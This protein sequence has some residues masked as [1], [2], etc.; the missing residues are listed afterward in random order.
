MPKAIEWTD[1]QDSTIRTMRAERA[2]W[3]AIAAA[4]RLSRYT[5]IERGRDIG[6][7]MAEREAQPVT[8]DSRIPLPAGHSVSWGAIN[9]ATCLA[10]MAYPLPVFV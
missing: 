4:L 7:V 10:G 8:D 6:A 2:S 9:A 5:V 1:A 3:D